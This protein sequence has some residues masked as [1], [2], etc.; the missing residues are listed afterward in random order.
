MNRSDSKA[1][2]V[3]AANTSSFRLATWQGMMLALLLGVGCLVLTTG[4]PLN[5]IAGGLMIDTDYPNA[6]AAFEIFV[7]D[8]WRWPV[9]ASP[10]FGGV[11]IFFSDGAPWFAFFSKAVL[12]L[13]G[14]FLAFHW[15][16]VINVLLF[17][18]MA[19][20]LATKVSEDESVRWLITV[21]LLF[22]L[23]MLVRMIGAQHIALGSYWV[24]LWAMCCVPVLNE[25]PRGLRRWE[26]LPAAGIAILS[27][28]YLG[29]M[30]ITIICVT[31]LF[32]RRWWAT[33]AALI[34]PALLLYCVGVFDGN[35]STTEGAKDYSLDLGAYAET[36]GWGLLPNLYQIPEPTQGD[37]ILYLG[38]GTWT[39]ALMGLVGVII[40]KL[41]G[42]DLAWSTWNT[43]AGFR[44]D[45]Q[46]RRLQILVMAALVLAFYA[47]TFKIRLVGFTLLKTD[48]PSIFM[49]FYERFRVTGRFGAPL[50]YMLIIGFVLLW[51]RLKP[52]MP[53]VLWFGVAALVILLQVLDVRVAGLKSPPQDWLAEAEDQRS[54]VASVLDEHEWSGRVFKTVGYFDLEQQRL[55]DRLLVDYGARHFEVVHGARLDP[56]EVIRRSG[57]DQAEPGD[58]VVLDLD[59]ASPAC[60]DQAVIKN[61]KLCLVE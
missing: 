37:A 42:A 51:G 49:P 46:Q 8:A 31:L 29:A 6:A 24:V 59:D 22:T 56:D 1:P 13:T 36:L 32:E 9:G 35:H 44:Q 38:T 30:A 58:A 19:R 52:W 26:F 47:L 43:P 34:W 10:H 17:A 57:F 2:P 20:R 16:I 28:A 4:N 12:S 40:L 21:L 23:I 54:A 39:L 3:T 11:N 25:A 33:L 60:Q 48:I 14:V 18:L 41:K 5:V 15:M 7:R 50:A 53:K 55:I 61:F 27:H 45:A